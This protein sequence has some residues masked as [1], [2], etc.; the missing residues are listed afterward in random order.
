MH[1]RR[2]LVSDSQNKKMSK[3]LPDQKT[4]KPKHLYFH[5]FEVQPPQNKSISCEPTKAYSSVVETLNPVHI[6]SCAFA[7]GLRDKFPETFFFVVLD[8]LF[9]FV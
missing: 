3:Q 7:I 9:R 4:S 5:H 8:V 2:K 6:I 1:L